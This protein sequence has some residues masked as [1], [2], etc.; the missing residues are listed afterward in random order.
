MI[1][2]RSCKIK[3]MV[4]LEKSLGKHKELIK[5]FEYLIGMASD[6]TVNYIYIEYMRNYQINQIL[7]DDGE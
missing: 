2:T 4:N 3:E 6:E 1:R 7:R 5:E